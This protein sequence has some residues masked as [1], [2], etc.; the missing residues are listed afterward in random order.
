M[1]RH[2]RGLG[3][4]L[5]VVL[6]LCVVVLYMTAFARP[7]YTSSVAFTVR[8]M[9]TAGMN[10]ALTGFAQFAGDPRAARMR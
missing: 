6:P 2:K 4:A 1:L 7:Q 3:F 9:D 5:L 10:D 8:S